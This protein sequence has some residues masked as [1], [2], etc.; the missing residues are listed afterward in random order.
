MRALAATAYGP[1][2]DLEFIDLPKPVPGPEHV[3]VRTE[4]TA[5]NAVDKALITGTMRHVLPVRHPFVP[6]V[7][8]SG[9]IE[10]VGAD[11]TRFTVGEAI[12]AW[13]GVPSGALAEYVLVKATAAAAV[14]PAGLTAAQGAALPT[15]A[16]TAAALLDISGTSP[17]DTVLVVGA[18]GGVGSYLVQLAGQA[19]LVV[20]ATGRTGDQEFLDGLGALHTIDYQHVDITEEAL[21]LVPGG[22]DVVFDLANTG[23]ALALTAGAAR[24]GGRL[25]SPLGGPASFERGVTAVYGGTTTPDG[26]LAA[27]AA[28]AA[29]GELRIAI[30]AEYAFAEARRALVDFAHKHIRGKVTI[31]F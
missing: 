2:E 31:T 12:V 30:G 14:R 1:L 25:V 27:L 4:A 6:G 8:V 22:V 10:A 17:G 26:R 24:G 9:V 5:L 21:R 18:G 13:N 20:L 28:Q 15:A 19:G 11:V 16:L 23:P 3:L 7:D 29:T